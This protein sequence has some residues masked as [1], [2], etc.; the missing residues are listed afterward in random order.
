MSITHFNHF[1]YGNIDNFTHGINRE[2]ENA[3]L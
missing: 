2:R 3:N 1:K